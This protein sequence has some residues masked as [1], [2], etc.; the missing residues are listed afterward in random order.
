MRAALRVSVV[1]ALLALA[2]PRT[3]SAEWQFTPIIGWTFAGS[4]T[5]SDFFNAADDAHWHFGGA[6]TV[7][8]DGP[9]GVEG[10]YLRTPGFFEGEAS[11]V[12]RPGGPTITNSSTD[13]FMGNVVLALPRA[14][15][16]YGLRPFLSGGV[17]KIRASYDELVLPL[18]VDV[19]G[20]N[21]G[22][23]AVGFLTDRVGLRFDLRYFRNLRDVSDEDRDLAP[24]T[25]G[26]PV[27]LRY[28]TAALGV[29][30]KAW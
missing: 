15:N 4:T 16:R 29:V 27:R 9:F 21:L 1:A 30:I 7:I 25:G 14:L 19:L 24:T 17:G 8:G 18:R 5:I 23:G 11:I 20:M 10:Y 28:W 13:A 3:A 2:T 26:E 22:G 6:V 12:V